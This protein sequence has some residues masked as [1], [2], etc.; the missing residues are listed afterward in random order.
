MKRTLLFV[1]ISIYILAIVQVLMTNLQADEA[2]HPTQTDTATIQ[3]Q[4]ERSE[5]ASAEDD[6]PFQEKCYKCHGNEVAYKEWKSSG[7]FK[8]LVNLRHGAH[9]AK[10]SCLTCHS[11]GY[12]SLI[13]RPW[14]A[15]K[16]FNL[17]TAVNAIACS[18]CHLH[19]SNREHYLVVPA[20]NLCVSCHK[21]D[22][23]CAGA[24][25]IHQSQSEMFLGREGN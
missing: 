13:N 16:P 8:A 5:I 21:M 2:R 6:N 11:S 9:P 24:G 1:S 22:C 20:K 18:S 7:H 25:I 10:D 4:V 17:E 15:E 14:P 23:G 19:S 3:T 12:D